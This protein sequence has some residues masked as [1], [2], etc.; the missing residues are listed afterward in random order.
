MVNRA[1]FTADE[2][3]F[4]NL[5]QDLVALLARRIAEKDL[6]A[7]SVLKPLALHI[8]PSAYA[9]MPE[10]SPIRQELEEMSWSIA[11]VIG[12]KRPVGKL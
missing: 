12:L 7:A 11:K 6:E 2:V 9:G 8:I 10:G 3:V 5:A 4:C 1:G